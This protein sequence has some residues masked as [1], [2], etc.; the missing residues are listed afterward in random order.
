[1]GARH[2]ALGARRWAL[3][4]GHRALGAGHSVPSATSSREPLVSSAQCLAP[5]AQRLAA[6]LIG[7]KRA[8]RGPMTEAEPVAAN[9]ANRF[10]EFLVV[11]GFLHEG[12]NAQPIG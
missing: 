5:S 3:G 10:D 9:E 1:M 4:A 8:M 11:Q 2:R 12:V 6:H 7:L